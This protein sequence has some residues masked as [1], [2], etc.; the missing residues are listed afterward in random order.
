EKGERPAAVDGRGQGVE[1]GV[2]ADG[3]GKARD[4]VAARHLDGAEAGEVVGQELAVE[5]RIAAGTEAGDEMDQR[6]LGGVGLAAEH[7]LAEEGGADRDAIEAA[8]K[9]SVAP[10]L[11]GVA[12]AGVEKRAVEPAD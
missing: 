12:V 8:D 11:D 7:A 1:V 4:I 6:H 2:A 5:Q 10:A 9:P 3:F